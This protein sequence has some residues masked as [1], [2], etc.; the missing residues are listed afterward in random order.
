MDS[1]ASLSRSETWRLTGLG[2]VCVAIIAG[3]FQG[4]GTPL[5]ASVALSGIAFAVTFSFVRWSAPAFLKAGMKGR[6]MAKPNKPEVYVSIT[7]LKD[8]GESVCRSLTIA[9][10]LLGQRL[11]EPYAQSCIF[12]CL[13]SSFLLP[14]TRILLR[15]HLEAEVEMLSSRF[16]RLKQV[17]FFIDSPMAKSGPPSSANRVN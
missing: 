1:A 8:G 10:P 3:T 13:S 12:C 11:W 16:G 15:L 2:V 6:D 4:D 14:F 17:D 5:I 9:P 7:A